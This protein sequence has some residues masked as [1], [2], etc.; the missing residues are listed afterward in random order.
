MLVDVASILGSSD[1]VFGYNGPGMV[2][3]DIATFVNS[4]WLVCYYV[5][6]AWRLLSSCVG[7]GV[8]LP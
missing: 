2:V 3:I 8:R 1:A 6:V 7:A 5:G 4:S